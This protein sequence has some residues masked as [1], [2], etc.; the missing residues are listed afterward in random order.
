MRVPGP[1]SQ[2]SKLS[3]AALPDKKQFLLWRSWEPL[4][5]FPATFSAVEAQ[6]I[7]GTCS[8]MLW[9]ARALVDSGHDVQVLGATLRDVVEEGVD[10]VGAGSRLEQEAAIG[11]GRVREPFAVLLE[12]GSAAAPFFRERFPETA[13]VQIGQN[14]DRWGRKKILALERYVDV[15][16][17]VSPGQL[18]LYSVREPALRHKMAMVRNA[19]PW[20]RFHS[21][22]PEVPSVD[23]VAWIGAWS[24][25]GLRDWGV[26]MERILR[27]HSG[28]RWDLYGPKYGK[29]E[30]KLPPEVFHGLDLPPDRIVVRSLPMPRMLDA[31]A[32][33]RIVGVSLGNESGPSSALDGHALGKPVVSGNDMVYA[34][35]NPVS[36]G[37]R[38]SNATEIY[39]AVTALI[40]GE[41]LCRRLG[42]AGRQL[43]RSEYSEEAQQADLVRLIQQI[44]SSKVAGPVAATD[45]TSEWQEFLGD[46][47]AIVQRKVLRVRARFAQATDN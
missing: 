10:F 44:E 41:D 22:V 32:G 43:A 9:H 33:A 46:L 14:I 4:Y 34:Y 18:A 25:K 19:V 27:E 1:C 21:R 42:E 15:Y 13:I 16:A 47:A 6:A 36:A 17:L 29:G 37:L 24:K 40:C 20:Q 28:W 5:E 39:E 12:G 3:G 26:A 31:V 7:G 38:A 11:S 45:G 8:Q 35:A 30:A 2:K 23:T